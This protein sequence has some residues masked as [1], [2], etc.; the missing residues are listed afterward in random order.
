LRED[1]IERRPLQTIDSPGLRADP[2]SRKIGRKVEWRLH[3]GSTQDELKRIEREAEDGTVLL[4]ETQDSGRGRLARNWFSPLGGIW[5][6]VLL[7]P[8]QPASHQLLT[9]SFGVAVTRAIFGVT[10]VSG[11]LK[12]PNDVMI[13]SRKVAGILA[14]STYDGTKLKHLIVGIGVNVNIRPTLFPERLRRSATSLSQELGREIDRD[15]LTRRMLEEMDSTYQTFESGRINELLEE[16]RRICSTVGRRVRVTTV[17]GNFEGQARNVGDDG[18]LLV[19]LRNGRTV[20]VYAAD[21]V[22][23]R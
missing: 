22:H 9:L 13:R 3:I 11:L 5:M 2:S 1:L 8:A 21:V 4:A 18:R 17:E 14:E 6:S 20:S 16:V 23:L 19:R 10:G 15:L 7:R 12:W